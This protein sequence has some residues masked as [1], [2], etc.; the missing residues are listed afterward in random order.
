MQLGDQ[1]WHQVKKFSPVILLGM[2]F[3]GLKHTQKTHTQIHKRCRFGQNWKHK[4]K[5]TGSHLTINLSIWLEQLHVYRTRRSYMWPM[6]ERQTQL[7][8]TITSTS[9]ATHKM[10]TT[11]SIVF[12]SFVPLMVRMDWENKIKIIN[13]ERNLEVVKSLSIGDPLADQ[14]NINNNA[15]TFQKSWMNFSNEVLEMQTEFMLANV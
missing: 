3:D 15:N 2:L 12:Q 4:L 7:L 8:S 13:Y 10:H 5:K 6:A 11:Q 9:R 1:V 14:K